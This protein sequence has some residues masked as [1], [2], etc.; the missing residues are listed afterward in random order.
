M[1]LTIFNRNTIPFSIVLKKAS[2]QEM[3]PVSQC[4]IMCDNLVNCK[5]LY[6]G[7][8]NC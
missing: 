2:K 6:Q 3:I 4:E 5:Y 1:S 8:Y 7:I